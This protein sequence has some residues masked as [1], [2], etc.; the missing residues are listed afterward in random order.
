MGAWEIE[1]EE[2][3]NEI[4]KR[5]NL[6]AAQLTNLP[7][8]YIEQFSS[9]KLE[10]NELDLDEVFHEDSVTFIITSAIKYD[11]LDNYSIYVTTCL[12]SEKAA[13]LDYRLT[14]EKFRLKDGTE[15]SIFKML[16]PKVPSL[17]V[18]YLTNSN[19]IKF[20]KYQIT[21]ETDLKVI[22]DTRFTETGASRI[23]YQDENGESQ[24]FLVEGYECDREFLPSPPLDNSIV[25]IENLE[26][27]IYTFDEASNL[28]IPKFLELVVNHVVFE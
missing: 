19:D 2:V 3:P 7:R 15:A 1:F 6:P 8:N 4:I 27:P 20:R 11:T 24:Q 21:I 16:H 14:G 25:L 26:H 18:T 22:E 13:S 23:S 28:Y 12:L 17:Q 5:W 9:V 10:N